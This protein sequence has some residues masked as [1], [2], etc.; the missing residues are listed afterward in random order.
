MHDAGVIVKYDRMRVG[1]NSALIQ[2]IN[3]LPQAAKIKAVEPEEHPWQVGGFIGVVARGI[4]RDNLALAKNAT[5][6]TIQVSEHVS[7]RET[8]E[9]DEQL[10]FDVTRRMIIVVKRGNFSHRL[11][12]VMRDFE[13]VQIVWRNKTLLQH[14]TLEKIVPVV[15]ICAVRSIHKDDWHKR[16]FPGLQ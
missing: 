10:A 14:V 11:V 4:H 9:A 8:L 5:E 3:H 6:L 15:P 2:R 12:K 1:D 16:T 7:G 13:Q